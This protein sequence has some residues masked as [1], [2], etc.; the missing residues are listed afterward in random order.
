MGAGAWTKYVWMERWD[1]RES[2]A[3]IR[4][5]QA[6]I[7]RKTAKRIKGIGRAYGHGGGLSLETNK[8]R[9]VSV[10]WRQVIIDT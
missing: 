2:G 4:W 8:R 3:G 7:K 6:N 10:K 1:K 5:L 9:E